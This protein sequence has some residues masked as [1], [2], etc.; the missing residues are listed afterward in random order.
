MGKSKKCLSRREV[1]RRSAS[2][3]AASMEEFIGDEEA[4]GLRSMPSRKVL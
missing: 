4:N 3:L 2:A 1:L